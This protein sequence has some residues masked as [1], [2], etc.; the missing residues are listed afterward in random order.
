MPSRRVKEMGGMKIGFLGLVSNNFHLR[1]STGDREKYYL[2]EPFEIAKKMVAELKAK[3]CDIIICVAHMEENEQ[4][5][6]AQ[7]LKGCPV[8]RKRACA[9]PEPRN[10]RGK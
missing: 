2:A 8:F 3:G 7:A 5:N 6:L 4:K 1:Q 9:H 10:A